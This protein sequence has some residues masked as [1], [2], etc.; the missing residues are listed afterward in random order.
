MQNANPFPITLFEKGADHD[1]EEHTQSQPRK[2]RA[3]WTPVT[4]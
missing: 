2:D 3:A 1:D 4:I